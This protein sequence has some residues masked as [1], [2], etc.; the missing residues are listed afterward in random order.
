MTGTE[1]TFRWTDQA[2]RQWRKMEKAR[3]RKNLHLVLAWGPYLISGGMLALG[4]AGRDGDA[5]ALMAVGGL[6]FL[7]FVVISPYWLFITLY[8]W[9]KYRDEFKGTRKSFRDL[10]QFD[11]CDAIPPDEH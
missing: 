9:K 7:L 11:P 2:R 5:R 3:K 8:E 4:G 10:Y 1:P 6:I